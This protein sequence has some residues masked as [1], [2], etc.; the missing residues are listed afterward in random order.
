[1]KRILAGITQVIDY[2]VRVRVK[3]DRNGV[4]SEDVKLSI[5]PFG[6]IAVEEALRAKDAGV[7]EEVVVAT[8]GSTDYETQLRAALA[9]RA[10]RALVVSS[11]TLAT[12]LRRRLRNTLR[13]HPECPA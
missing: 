5:N 1:M 8:I 2:N 11:P 9:T 7:C 10:D 13:V 3:P 4:V 12:N 6:K